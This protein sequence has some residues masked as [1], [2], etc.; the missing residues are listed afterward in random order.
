[1]LTLTVSI[2]PHVFG[3]FSKFPFN[4]FRWTAFSFFEYI[5]FPFVITC[6]SRK[7]WIA[8]MSKFGFA[9]NT[10]KVL[11]KRTNTYYG[12]SSTTCIILKTLIISSYF[13]MTFNLI[14][15]SIA[16][17]WIPSRNV[18][19]SFCL[20]LHWLGRKIPIPAEFRWRTASAWV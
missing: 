17:D 7:V 11:F 14:K 19:S 15:P 5:K 10:S 1:M 13:W 8:L 2:P 16:S 4:I 6:V 3:D 12:H 18:Q 9:C 20:L